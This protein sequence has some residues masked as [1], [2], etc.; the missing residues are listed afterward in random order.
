M[1]KIVVGINLEVVF[2]KKKYMLSHFPLEGVLV[3]GILMGKHLPNHKQFNYYPFSF[4]TPTSHD[5]RAAKFH[6]T[7]PSTLFLVATHCTY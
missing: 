1:Q 2:G 5:S 6:I 7:N 3:E 4:V